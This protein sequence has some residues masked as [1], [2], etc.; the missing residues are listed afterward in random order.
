MLARMQRKENPGA[1]QGEQGTV[2]GNVVLPSWTIVRRL[3]QNKNKKKEYYSAIKIEN[4]KHCDGRWVNLGGH[5]PLHEIGQQR[6]ANTVWCHL[7][8]ESKK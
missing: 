5:L 3:L 7:Y 4:F 2:G 6:K 1:E 8:E